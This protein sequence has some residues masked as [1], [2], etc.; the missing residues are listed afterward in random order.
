[1]DVESGMKALY[2]FFNSFGCKAYINSDVPDMANMP[3]ITYQVKVGGDMLHTCQVL[4][5]EKSENYINVMNRAKAIVNTIGEGYSIPTE[6]GAIYV[7]LG[8]PT[9]QNFVQPDNNIKCLYLNLYIRT[10]L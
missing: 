10:L 2:T 6:Q 9:I 4:I 7:Y 8:S 3:Y 1:M 5:Y